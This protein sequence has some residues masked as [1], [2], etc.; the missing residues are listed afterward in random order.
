MVRPATAGGRKSPYCAGPHPWKGASTQGA[1]G[2]IGL[3]SWVT[4]DG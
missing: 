3:Q 1:R 4:R 2:V